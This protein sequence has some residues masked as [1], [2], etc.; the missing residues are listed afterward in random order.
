L[1]GIRRVKRVQPAA[2]G[3]CG[4]NGMLPQHGDVREC[5]EAERSGVLAGCSIVFSR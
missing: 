2:G 3:G 1:P 4:G 5:L